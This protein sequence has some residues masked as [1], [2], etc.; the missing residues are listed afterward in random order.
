M[1]LWLLKGSPSC[2]RLLAHLF[3]LLFSSFF[4][5]PNE[6]LVVI[7]QRP[8]L[9]RFDTLPPRSFDLRAIQTFFYQP[10]APAFQHLS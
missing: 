8:R 3:L 2:L 5:C 6:P 1:C 7:S 9:L 4:L 10:R